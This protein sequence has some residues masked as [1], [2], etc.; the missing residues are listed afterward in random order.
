MCAGPLT[1]AYTGGWHLRSR[2]IAASSS[3]TQ[4]ISRVR[5]LAR[6]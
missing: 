4:D 5:S 1:S 6:G 3:V 2:M